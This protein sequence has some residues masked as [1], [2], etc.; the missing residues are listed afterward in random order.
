M[1]NVEYSTLTFS[2]YFF[3]YHCSNSSVISSFPRI[4]VPS[5]SSIVSSSDQPPSSMY[6]SQFATR[7]TVTSSS[8]CFPQ[9]THNA[10]SKN[11]THNAIPF[12]TV[13]LHSFLQS[14]YIYSVILHLS[15]FLDLCCL[16]L[17]Q[18]APPAKI[19]PLTVPK[20]PS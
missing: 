1:P 5:A 14:L 18:I 6:S 20:E 3:S 11:K 13:F 9:P 7:S 17:P 10:D 8:D 19:L 12:F 15:T 4:F 16:S 2:P